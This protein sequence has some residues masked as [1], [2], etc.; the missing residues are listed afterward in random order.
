MPIFA[1]I[2]VAGVAGLPTIDTNQSSVPGV[3]QVRSP[4]RRTAHRSAGPQRA[5]RR[6]RSTQINS[7]EAANNVTGA[8]GRT[9]TFATMPTHHANA[10]CFR[11]A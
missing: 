5:R 1:L 3:D 2:C 8:T 9:L 7:T 4:T 11:S 10:P 6:R